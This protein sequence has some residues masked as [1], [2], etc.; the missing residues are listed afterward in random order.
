MTLWN[1]WHHFREVPEAFPGL[2]LPA[3]L[4]NQL[5]WDGECGFCAAMVTRLRHFA[6]APF[7]A[8]PYQEVQGELP[9]E[10]LRWSTRQMHWV[11]A[12]GRVLG[13]SLALGR[14]LAASGHPMLAAWLTCPVMRP[15]T[16]LGYRLVADHRS[17]FGR[18]VG[19]ECAL[20]QKPQSN[21]NQ[22]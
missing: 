14:V 18:V 10:V 4:R 9:A 21:Q 6:R 19:E 8:R 7:Q 12:D 3:S 22:R 20:P 2:V 13:G 1:R 16:W 15:F 17:S 11:C 5:V